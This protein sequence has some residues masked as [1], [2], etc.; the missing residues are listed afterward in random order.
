MSPM[1]LIVIEHQAEVKVCPNCSWIAQSTLP[2]GITTLTQFGSGFKTLLIYINGKHFIPFLRIKE[3]YEDVFERSVDKGT[4]LVANDWIA[5]KLN[6]AIDCS[7]EHSMKTEKSV[8]CIFPL[9][10]LCP[11][12][13]HKSL[14]SYTNP[15]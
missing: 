5:E 15:Q 2:T 9:L 13:H 12:F 14:S 8:Q 11:N 6:L 10:L 3:L 7:R 1:Q 4:I